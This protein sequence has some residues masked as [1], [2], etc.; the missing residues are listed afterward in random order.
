LRRWR[1]STGTRRVAL[2]RAGHAEVARRTLHAFQRVACTPCAAARPRE[3]QLLRAWVAILLSPVHRRPAS[4]LRA[5]LYRRWD[6]AVPPPPATTRT[7][8]LPSYAA[9]SRVGGRV[10]GGGGISPWQVTLPAAAHSCT[11]C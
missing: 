2:L 3:W 11:A 6:G 5:M 4:F 1:R 10:G 7:S 8:C 9:P